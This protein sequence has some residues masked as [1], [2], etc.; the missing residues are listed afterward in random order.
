[1]DSTRCRRT[2]L[3]AL[4]VPGL[5]LGLAIGLSSPEASAKV[6]KCQDATGKIQYADRPCYREQ[7]QPYRPPE[8]TMVEAARVTGG[9]K[10][11]AGRN[12]RTRSLDPVGECRAR[13][14][15]IDRELRTCRLP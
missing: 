6:Y 5:V 13:G 11:D 12:R 7:T 2:G 4:A 15:E 1:M 9:R 8:L 3:G 14:G 10:A